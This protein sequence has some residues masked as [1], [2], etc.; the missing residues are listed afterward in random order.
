[1]NLHDHSKLF[2]VWFLF[3]CV[4]S[5]EKQDKSTESPGTSSCVKGF[6]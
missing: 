1:M 6:Y 2:L 3:M 5:K 4:A